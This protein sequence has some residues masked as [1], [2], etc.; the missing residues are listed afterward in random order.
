MES[1]G[2]VDIP[3]FKDYLDSVSVAEDKQ[4]YFA[5][6]DRL[7][8]A[9]R[10]EPGYITRRQLIDK[11][12]QERTSL[13][14]SNPYLDAE[15]SKKG[16]NRGDLKK[17]FISLSEAV[18]EPKSPIDLSTRSAMNLAIKNVSEFLTLADDPAMGMRWDF[19]SMK[20]SKKE[21]VS[22]ILTELGKT[23]PI[24]KEANRIIFTGLLNFYSRE[25]IIAGI[26]D[27]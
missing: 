15:I 5:I 26:E 18:A 2:L 3:D 22:N 17:M 6:D 13:L 11:A 27:R 9:L 10:K 14:L 21:Q 7:N 23:N 16:T 20:A 12:A 4:K 8:E 19:S 25:S 24:V 1:E